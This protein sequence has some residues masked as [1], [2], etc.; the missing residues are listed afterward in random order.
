MHQQITHAYHVLQ[1]IIILECPGR[2]IAT[3]VWKCSIQLLPGDHMGLDVN[4]K[5]EDH[6][7]PRAQKFHVA[8]MGPSNN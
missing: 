3:I 5:P 8:L 4:V 2:L 7:Q 1:T 6:S